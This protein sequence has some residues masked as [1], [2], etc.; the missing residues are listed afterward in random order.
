MTKLTVFAA[1]LKDEPMGCKGPVLSEPLL[2]NHAI[3]CLTF[4][5]NTG[6]PFNDNLWLFRLLALH[7]H[8]TQRLQEKT[9]NFFELLINK[10]DGLSADQFQRVHM[11]IIRIVEDLLTLN[12]LLY[13]IDIVDGA[14]IGEL[15][16]RNVQKYKNTVRLL[17]YHNHICYV[18]NINAVFQSFR[19]PNCDNL[20]N[21]TFNLERYL[22]TCSE[23]VKNV[24]SKKVYQTKNLSLTS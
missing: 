7:L 16:R 11:N 13:D 23:R 10:M 18:N 9:S 14:I 3:N 17:R 19:S 20:F 4:E 12:I 1:L 5:E 22:T 2:R 21:R 6:Q 24:Y 15:A 8:G